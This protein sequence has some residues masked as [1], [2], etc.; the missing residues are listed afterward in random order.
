M[1]VGA[2]L[3]FLLIAGCGLGGSA[4]ATP[5]S[6]PLT[7]PLAKASGQLH[8]QV[9]APAGFPSD[10]PTYPGSRLTAGASFVSSGQATW[11]ME[12]ETLDAVAKVQAFYAGKMNRGDWTITFSSTS[13]TAFAATFARKSNSH[14][15]GFLASSNASGVTKILMSLLEVSG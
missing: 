15:T 1:R 5:S 9:P 6:S 10:V 8:A 4:Q 3:A 2:A 12:W 7:S 13:S 14:V 11:S